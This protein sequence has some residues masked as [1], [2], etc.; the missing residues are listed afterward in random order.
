MPGLVLL[1]GPGMV[2]LPALLLGG[3]AWASR[4]VVA[5]RVAAALPPLVVP[6]L[7]WGSSSPGD[8]ALIS[9]WIFVGGFYVLSGALAAAGAVWFAPWTRG[10]VRPETE[11]SLVA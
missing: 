8:R 2:L 1:A 10:A 11:A 7:L 5:L 4:R 3:W 6:L 9:P